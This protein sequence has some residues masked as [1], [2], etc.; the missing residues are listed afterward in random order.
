M[1][2]LKGSF[3]TVAMLRTRLKL[4]IN[5]KIMQKR[6][7]WLVTIHSKTLAKKDTFKIGIKLERTIGSSFLFFKRGCMTACLKAEGTHPE[8]KDKLTRVQ[9]L[10]PTVL[11]TR[12][13]GG[14][15]PA[16][17]WETAEQRRD[18]GV[19]NRRNGGKT[20]NSDFLSKLSQEVLTQSR[21]R[22]NMLCVTRINEI[23][24]NVKKI[25]RLLAVA[26]SKV[27]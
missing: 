1:H 13:I 10:D 17:Y 25:L 16:H 9:M 7:H 21:W 5:T 24:K 23:V 12:Q 3:S 14:M 18:R 4:W 27:G 26:C 8:L 11:Q 22:H 2:S 15:K 20:N 6:F 19:R